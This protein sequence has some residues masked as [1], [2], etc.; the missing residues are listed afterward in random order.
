[1]T[2]GKSDNYVVDHDH[3]SGALRAVLCRNCNGIEGR[4]KRLAIRCS[5]KKTY[6]TWLINLANYYYKH[7]EPQTKFTHPTHL[8]DIEKR[9]KKNKSARAAYKKK[10]LQEIRDK[11]KEEK[12]DTWQ[13]V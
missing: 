10:K 6:R 1:M 13:E 5:S 11:A 3:E 4:I 9:L 7:R 8:T 2:R 12:G